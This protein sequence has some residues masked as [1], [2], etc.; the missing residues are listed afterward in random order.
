MG[1]LTG[2]SG[3][4]GLSAVAGRRA[5][6]PWLPTM[7]SSLRL[8]IDPSDTTGWTLDGSGNP[9]AMRSK[10]SSQDVFTLAAGVAPVLSEGSLTATDTNTVFENSNL[11]ALPPD[12]ALSVVVSGTPA[13]NVFTGLFQWGLNIA[14]DRLLLVFNGLDYAWR[15]AASDGVHRAPSIG[16]TQTILAASREPGLERTLDR[17]RANGITI[18]PSLISQGGTN[19]VSGTV[20]IFS[21]GYQGTLDEIL[22]FSST[23]LSLMERT[24][25]YLAHKRGRT[26]QLPVTHPYKFSPPMVPAPVGG[27]ALDPDAAFYIAAVEAADGQPLEPALV[28]AYN[29]FIVGCKADPSPFAGVSNYDA[30][31]ASCVMAGARTLAGAL[32]PF[33]GPAPTNNG[34]VAGDYGRVTGLK[35]N[36]VN[37]WLNLNRSGNSD[38]QDNFHAAVFLMAYSGPVSFPRLL[39]CADFSTV[40][41]TSLY[42]RAPVNKW[43]QINRRSGTA[44]FASF[45]RTV[46]SFVGIGRQTSG[47]ALLRGSSTTDSVPIVSEP[48]PAQNW[49]AYRAVPPDEQFSSARLSYYSVGE[50]VDLAALDSRI[51]T[52]MAAIAAALA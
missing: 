48:P 11:L 49:L 40:G 17:I 20:R 16:Q 22:A 7:E 45:E 29:E 33:V 13:N 25:G 5:M 31:K 43:G 14:S 9:T 41:A 10:A 37:K 34:F 18:A 8:W 26:A 2:L 35:G 4:S 30:I 44:V 46:P 32:V 38:P 23:D 21:G 39:E 42:E 52:L 51:T 27:G 24:E 50:A 15:R 28:T 12:P 6:I 36:G 47:T 3:A 19:Q 1:A